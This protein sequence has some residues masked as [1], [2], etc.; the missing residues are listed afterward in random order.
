[1]RLVMCDVC[2]VRCAVCCALKVEFNVVTNQSTLKSHASKIQ[3]LPAGTVTYEEVY[4]ERVRGVVE[5]ELQGVTPARGGGRG[6][7]RFA[8]EQASTREPFGGKVRLAPAPASASAAAAPDQKQAPGPLY[9]FCLR[10]NTTSTLH[11]C[12]C[13]CSPHGLIDCCV[14]VAAAVVAAVI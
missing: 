8:K 5:R 1:M 14:A 4:P 10:Y 13:L 2:C 6:G 11:L 12:T 9:E 7:G 3:I